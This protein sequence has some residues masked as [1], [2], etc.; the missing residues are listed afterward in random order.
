MTPE[1]PAK[2]MRMRMPARGALT[3]SGA[4]S[5]MGG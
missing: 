3:A 5:P 1:A 4:S 2:Y